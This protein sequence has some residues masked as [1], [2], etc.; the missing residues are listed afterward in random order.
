MDGRGLSSNWIV[1]RDAV[2]EHW[3]RLTEDDVTS[4]SG[5]RSELLRAI[6]S[7]YDQSFGEIERA[8]TEFEQRDIRAAYTA[9]PSLGI[10]NGD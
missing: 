3:P 5:S 10:I 7:R 2:R 8:L 9:R 4:I 6:K 1:A